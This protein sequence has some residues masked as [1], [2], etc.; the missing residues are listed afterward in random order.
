MH[1]IAL[2]KING[3]LHEGRI[4]YLTLLLND[5][6]DVNSNQTNTQ[7]PTNNDAQCVIS[8]MVSLYI[9]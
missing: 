2:Y 3:I 8:L 4:E 7:L 6:Y 9:T 1:M 5:M